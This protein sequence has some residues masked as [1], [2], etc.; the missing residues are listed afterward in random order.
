MV[1]YVFFQHTT[2]FFITLAGL[3]ITLLDVNAFIVFQ[4]AVMA[5]FHYIYF[6]FREY[7]KQHICNERQPL[8]QFDKH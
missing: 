5:A 8:Q 4:I 3:I 1:F 6:L 7:S 2:L